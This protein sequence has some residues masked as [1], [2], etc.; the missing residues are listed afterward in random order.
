MI[1]HEKTTYYVVYDKCIVVEGF[2]PTGMP[3]YS[4]RNGLSFSSYDSAMSYLTTQLQYLVTTSP[5]AVILQELTKY[6]VMQMTTSY[7][8][9]GYPGHTMCNA[10]VRN[11]DDG[12]S[13]DDRTAG[14]H[15]CRGLLKCAVL[16]GW[17]SVGLPTEKILET[18][19]NPKYSNIVE[20]TVPSHMIENFDTFMEHGIKTCD[21]D[22]LGAIMLTSSEKI[23]SF[24]EVDKYNVSR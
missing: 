19:R 16:N 4:T 14:F 1:N 3:I 10:W 7:Q 20:C 12:V 8:P 22:E 2:H 24:L 6:E 18:L 15:V 17:N 13:Y 11:F 23:L 5:D 9:M 21:P